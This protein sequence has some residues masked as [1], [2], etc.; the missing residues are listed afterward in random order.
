MNVTTLRQNSI[1]LATVALACST[2]CAKPASQPE[3]WNPVHTA[4]RMERK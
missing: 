1:L 2:L 3:P 4:I